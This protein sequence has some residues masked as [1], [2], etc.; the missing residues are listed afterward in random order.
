MEKTCVS[1][2]L[3]QFCYCLFGQGMFF[4]PS[5]EANFIHTGT[6]DIVYLWCWSACTQYILNYRCRGSTIPV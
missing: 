3:L 4:L 1:Y 6:W 2:H 5:P